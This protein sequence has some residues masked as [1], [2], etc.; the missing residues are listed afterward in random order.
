M[1]IGVIIAQENGKILVGKRCGSYAPYWSIPGGHLELGE[2]FE[3]AAIR[4]VLEE[5]GL[6][7]IKPRV[8]AVVNNLKTFQQENLHYVSVCLLAQYQGDTVENREPDKCEG[9]LWVAPDNLPTP[10]F[11]ASEQAVCCYRQDQFYIN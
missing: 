7:I 2:T 4:E 1:G 5:T 3:Q 8:I 10:H 6:T 11:E 9:W